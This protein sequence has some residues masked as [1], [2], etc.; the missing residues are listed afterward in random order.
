MAGTE[1]QEVK[2]EETAETQDVSAEVEVAEEAETTP[3]AVAPELAQQWD[4]ERQYK[5]ELMAEREKR[6]QAQQASAQE[7]GALKAQL[8]A[9]QE[10]LQ[11]RAKPESPADLDD[12]DVLKNTVR[13]LTA[14]FQ[15]AE[16]EHQA[17]IAKAQ[18]GR[19]E[20]AQQVEAIQAAQRERD[21]RDEG[22]RLLNRECAILAKRY[23]VE[24]ANNAVIEQVTKDFNENQIATLGDVPRARWIRQELRLRFLDAAAKAKREKK[25]SKDTPVVDTGGSG[26]P[27]SEKLKP[28]THKDV[29]RDM[30]AR[31]LREAGQA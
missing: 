20:S 24:H 14:R 12:Y 1:T 2:T 4:K 11:E 26:S 30:N 21:G 5:D 28:G 18:E 16:K 3:E 31:D 27:P 22:M 23:G 8:D 29:S 25:T 7:V 10:T 6:E 15:S 13:D 9:V 17:A 19:Q